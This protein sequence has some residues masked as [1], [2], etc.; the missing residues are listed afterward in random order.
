M[1]ATNPREARNL[2][3]GIIGFRSGAARASCNAGVGWDGQERHSSSASKGQA[4][5]LAIHVRHL[6]SSRI[7]L[8]RSR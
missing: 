8:V 7:V 1:Y 2:V 3:K 4:L 6:L 5:S